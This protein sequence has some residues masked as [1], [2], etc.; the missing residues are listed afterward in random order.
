M[1]GLRGGAF[2][3]EPPYPEAVVSDELTLISSAFKDGVHVTSSIIKD[4]G[5]WNNANPTLAALSGCRS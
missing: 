3:G 1:R 5:G 4:W 2:Y